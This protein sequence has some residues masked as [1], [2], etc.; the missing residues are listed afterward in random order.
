[1]NLTSIKESAFKNTPSLKLVKLPKS[2]NNIKKEAFAYSGIN[3]I[4]TSDLHSLATDGFWFVTDDKTNG[5]SVIEEGVFKGCANLK[6]IKLP[7]SI[8]HLE[9]LSFA[10][11]DNIQNFSSPGLKTIA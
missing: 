11:C 6:D 9:T 4:V 8:E 3:K 2:V 5:L 10:E 1:L 7:D